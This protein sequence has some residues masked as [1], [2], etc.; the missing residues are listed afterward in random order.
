MAGLRFLVLGDDFTPAHLF[1]DE[2][3]R[4]LG[5]DAKQFG[6]HCVDTDANGLPQFRSDE[7]SEA[8]G[9]DREVARLAKDC[10]LIVTTFAPVTKQVFEAAP[11]LLAVACGRGGP[12]N[13]NSSEATRR[14]IPVLYAPGRNVQAVAEFTVAGMINL[15]RQVPDAMDYLR[16]GQWQTPREDTFEKPS[17]PELSGRSVGLVGCGQVGRVVGRL[18]LAFGA[19]VLVFDPHL[20]KRRLEDMGF[21]P[22]TLEALL[23]RAE[24]ISIHARVGKGDPPVIGAAAYGAMTRR[25]YL[26]N[27]ARAAALDYDALVHALESHVITAAL[28]DVYPD[29][30]LAPDSPLLRMPKERLH[31]TPHVAGVSRDIPTNTARILADGLGDLLRSRRPQFV[32]NQ[33]TL[34]VCFQR[35]ESSKVHP[36]P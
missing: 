9:D 5:A 32:L 35:L 28:L 6:F 12:V 31:L 16:V 33:A 26:I 3:Q 13:I 17:G 8:F 30:P 7:V 29:E 10:D 11:D 15:M 21:E 1:R 34:E 23:A 18:V 22:V 36:A 27:T 4:A 20:E 14:G 2:I 24:V 25:P 19:R